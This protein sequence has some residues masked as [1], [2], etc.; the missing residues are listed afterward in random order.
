MG[1]EIDWDETLLRACQKSCSGM[2]VAELRDYWNTNFVI[3]L[4]MLAMIVEGDLRTGVALHR[5]NIAIASNEADCWLVQNMSKSSTEAVALVP[6]PDTPD[7]KAG[8]YIQVP[9]AGNW[10]IDSDASNHFTNMK[11]IPSDYRSCPDEKILTGNGYSIAKGVG[12]VTIHSSLGLRTIYD[13]FYG[14]ALSGKNNL[15]SI[16]QI[17]KKGCKITMSRTKGYNIYSDD[18]ESILLLKSTFTGKGFL[19]DISVCRTTT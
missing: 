12:N 2:S 18:N 19:V 3:P 9:Q 14:P 4:S 15:L 16:P 17:V 5:Y 11:H 13:V 10:L 6:E 7:L 8:D 1:Q